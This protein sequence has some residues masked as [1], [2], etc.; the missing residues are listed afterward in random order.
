MKNQNI[1]ED[2]HKHKSQ[3]SQMFNLQLHVYHLD[4]TKYVSDTAVSPVARRFKMKR[5][6][7]ISFMYSL[8]IPS[9]S[10]TTAHV[11]VITIET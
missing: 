9:P 3:G 8:L 6:E 4:D 7:I 1:L 5:E 11:P 2:G 10:V